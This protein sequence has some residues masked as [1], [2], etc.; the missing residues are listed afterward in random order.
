MTK[1]QKKIARVTVK[2]LRIEFR[3]SINFFVERDS[4]K[5][6]LKGW[7]KKYGLANLPK[8]VQRTVPTD[9]KVLYERK[10]Y[11]QP[12]VW[13]RIVQLTWLNTENEGMRRALNG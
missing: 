13:L 1:E 8:S 10:W 12:I 6:D 9:R 3:K 7:I 11:L 2:G 4:Y 5:K